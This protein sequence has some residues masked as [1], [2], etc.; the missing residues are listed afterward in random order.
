MKGQQFVLPTPVNV[1]DGKWRRLTYTLK[2]DPETEEWV[3]SDM[4]VE[5]AE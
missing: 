2:W 1:Q 4:T 3:I 5:V